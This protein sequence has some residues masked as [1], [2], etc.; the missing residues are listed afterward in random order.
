MGAANRIMLVFSGN[1][2]TTTTATIS[3]TAGNTWNALQAKFTQ[4]GSGAVYAWWALANGSGSTTITVNWS[5]NPL[6]FMNMLVDV[7]SGNETSS[8]ISATSTST[9]ASGAPSGTLTPL[10]NNCLLWGATNDSV[11]AVGAGFSKGADDAAQDWSEY[12]ELAGGSGA[13][14]TINFSGTSGAWMLVKAAIKPVGGGGATNW[15]PWMVNGLSWNRLVG[16]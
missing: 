13:S 12:K 15:G 16:A 9:A 2:D 14:Q 10:D 8:P 1:A 3:D 5:S 7:F 11:T 6:G 4:A